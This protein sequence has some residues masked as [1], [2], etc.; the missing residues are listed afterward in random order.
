MGVVSTTVRPPDELWQAARLWAPREG[1]ENALVV[2]AL[3]DAGVGLELVEQPLG[4]RDLPGLAHV[5]RHVE[6][7]VMAD[8]SVFDLE[9]LVAKM[10]D[11]A[12]EPPA[13]QPPADAD[14]LE[15]HA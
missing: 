14:A 12:S 6:T 1:N 3:E 8:E 7:P 10:L 11:A 5:R 13:D 4:R 2:R 15:P 9:D